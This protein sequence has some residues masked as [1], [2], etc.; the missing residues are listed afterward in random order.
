MVREPARRAGNDDAFVRKQ[1]LHRF[2]GCNEVAVGRDEDRRVE[3]VEKRILQ[4]LDCD[5]HVR[6]LL[7][8]DIPDVS[9]AVTRH[10]VELV[11]AEE[12][13]RVAERGDGVDVR[14]L[15]LHLLRRRRDP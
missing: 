13:R 1:L 6:H 2:D 15:P 14:R 4:K 12:N 5:V 11:L 8:R 9:A 10:R 3:R 7:A